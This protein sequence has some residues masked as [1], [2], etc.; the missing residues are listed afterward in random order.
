MA[1]G[2][3][4]CL[5]DSCWRSQLQSLEANQAMQ[6]P[7]TRQSAGEQL[8]RA[9][10]SGGS[11]EGE[12]FYSGFGWKQLWKKFRSLPHDSATARTRVLSSPLPWCSLKTRCNRARLV[13][14]APVVSWEG[15]RGGSQ[16]FSSIYLGSTEQ[17][18]L[19]VWGLLMG[20]S[21]FG[22]SCFIAF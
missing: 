11:T 20:L 10:V 2:S 14:L 16:R 5:M 4:L 13:R 7:V 18:A 6:P 12:C 15:L 8:S 19:S 22:I 21:I 1:S 9:E 17:N 3:P